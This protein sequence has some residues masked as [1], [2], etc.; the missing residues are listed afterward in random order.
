M[1]QQ[2]RGTEPVAAAAGDEPASVL[3]SGF[4]LAQ[5]QPN[6]FNPTT[7]IAF[8]LASSMSVR[9]EIFNSLGRRVRT[10][11]D[12]VRGAGAHRVTW[13][14]RSENG[15]SVPSGTYLYRLSAGDEV[16]SKTM[17]LLK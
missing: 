15:E 8:S 14:G 1:T 6:P 9:L 3:P 7:E 12:G 11:V 13:D 16:Q 4:D 5:N 2:A 17:T 10:L